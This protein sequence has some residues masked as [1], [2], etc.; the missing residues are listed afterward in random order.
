MISDISIDLKISKEVAQS[1]ALSV[2]KRHQTGGI[3]LPETFSHPDER[4]SSSRASKILLPKSS[5]LAFLVILVILM[6][7]SVLGTSDDDYSGPRRLSDAVP[8]QRNMTNSSKAKVI[9][10]TGKF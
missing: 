8:P 9:C 2:I 5:V 6:N 1:T 4:L 7:N 3:N 10:R